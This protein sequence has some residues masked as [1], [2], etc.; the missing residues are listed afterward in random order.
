[1]VWV[2][3]GFSGPQV[4]AN[5]HLEV[6][7]AHGSWPDTATQ[8]L[9]LFR[10]FQHAPSHNSFGN[11]VYSSLQLGALSAE[12]RGVIHYVVRGDS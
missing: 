1:M 12:Y 3:A 6:V 7:G 5:L 11:V 2:A 4:N 8:W 10:A 9:A